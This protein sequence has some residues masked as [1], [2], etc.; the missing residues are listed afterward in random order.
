MLVYGAWYPI[1]EVSSGRRLTRPNDTLTCW[2]FRPGVTMT[3]PTG[4]Q[5]DTP[6][7]IGGMRLDRSTRPWRLDFVDVGD[8]RGRPVVALGVC[9]FDGAELEWCVSFERWWPVRPLADHPNR[10]TA[11]ESTVANGWTYYRLRR[12]ELYQT[13]PPPP[14]R[15]P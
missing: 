5:M 12:C 8:G 1:E 9:R 10:P 15:K 3:W 4:G 11:F 13:T 6:D 2:W 7:T 14:A